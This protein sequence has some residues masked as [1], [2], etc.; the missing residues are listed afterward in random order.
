MNLILL[1]GGS[2]KRLWPLSDNI[3]SKQFLKLFAS[4]TESGVYESMV[5]RIY[6][7]I[8]EQID[9]VKITIATSESQTSIIRNQLGT[10]VDISVEPYRR[11]TF[12]AI[13]LACA[14]LIDNMNVPSHEPVIVCPVDSYVE[15]DYFEYL[16]ELHELIYNIESSLVLMGIKPT[17]PSE[18]YGYIIPDD[19][20][21][22]I[23]KVVEF[24]EK[25]SVDQAEVYIENGALWN[26]G[27]FGFKIDWLL[28]KAY[29]ILGCNKY[30]ELYD[31]YE[32]FDNISFDYA[33]VEKEP[34]SQVLRYGGKWKDLGTW[35]TL[36]EEMDST[37]WG[38]GIVDSASGGVNI[39]NE[40]DIPIL[41]MGLSDVVIS[42]SHNGILVSDKTQSSFIKPLVEGFEDKVIYAEKSWGSYEVI[43]IENQALV[44]KVTLNPGCSMNYHSH[45]NR[46]EQWI[47]ISGDGVVIIDEKKFSV[48]IGDRIFIPAGC[49]HTVMAK[50]ELKIVEIQIG[51]D[52]SVEDKEIHEMV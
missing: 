35:N 27:I 51:D 14:Y 2:G 24:K 30:Q 36:S 52:I 38:E 41:A 12:P 40:L 15:S 20:N 16:K 33:I 29:N 21:K 22:R 45:R 4:D 48:K 7:Q 1:S 47:V 23:S 50:T 26:G 8:S 3:R 43:D 18:K 39:I 17:Y 19:Q 25:P 13:S 34:N 46:D 42:A 44:I 28:D 10:D 6:R 32:S 49:R 37:V 31:N 9:N 11:D 5:Q